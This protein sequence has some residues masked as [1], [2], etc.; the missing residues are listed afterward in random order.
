MVVVARI[1][2]YFVGWNW[3]PRGVKEVEN[4]VPFRLLYVS[5]S[6]HCFDLM[7]CWA[8]ASVMQFCKK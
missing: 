2:L 1:S 6:F 8:F 3:L 7:T 4:G 5:A